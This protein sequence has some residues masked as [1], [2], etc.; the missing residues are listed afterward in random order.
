[1]KD[2]ARHFLLH[3]PVLAFLRAIA[4]R[5]GENAEKC[6]YVR[7]CGIGGVLCVGVTPLCV[8]IEG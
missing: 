3:A 5:C 8:S 7:V 4:V 6:V 1:M 2:S